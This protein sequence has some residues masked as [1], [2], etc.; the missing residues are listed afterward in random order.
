MKKP[1][2]FVA[3]DGL[4]NKEEETLRTAQM[5]AGSGIGFKINLDYILLHGIKRAVKQL[6]NCPVFVD[7]KMWNGGRTMARIVETLVD[8][9]VGYVN[10]YVLADKELRQVIEVVK[11]TKTKILGVTV[12]THY[13]DGYCQSIF[14]HALAGTV[15]WLTGKAQILGCSGVI[16]P[17]SCLGVVRG[18]D[19]TK[20]IPGVRPSWYADERHKAKITPRDAIS[21]GAD[22]LVCGSPIM[23]DPDPKKALGMI[24]EEII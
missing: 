7:L 6:P 22:I 23:K 15:V 19:I 14:G 16:L 3:L 2:L 20:V 13:G 1:F 10:A 5:L 21:R 8:L 4:V 11:G 17:G 24:L 18:I 12:L 9:E